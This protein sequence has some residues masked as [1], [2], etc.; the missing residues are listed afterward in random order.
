MF[1]GLGLAFGATGVTSSAHAHDQQVGVSFGLY[2]GDRAS[3]GETTVVAPLID[4]TF[5]ISE[6][7]QLRLAL[8]L[9]SISRSDDGAT[10]FALGNPYT[11]AYWRTKSGPLQFRLGAGVALPAARLTDDDPQTS[12]LQA[13]GYLTAAAMQG[14]KDRWLWTPERLS[15]VVPLDAKLDLGIVELRGDAAWAWMIP[16]NSDDNETM[17]QLGT[18]ALVHLG[19]FG[20]GARV[21]G[22][23][24]PTTSGDDLQMAVAPVA[25]LELGPVAARTMF[26]VNVDEPQGNSFDTSAPNTVWGWHI[27]AAVRF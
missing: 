7:L 23:W 1:L 13:E 3:T 6:S 15:V 8:P 14:L 24:V 21:Q 19:P 26:V 10:R 4:G 22:V 11:A 17:L 2:S 9:T 16:T 20:L 18:E 5:N 12:A 25:E 27:A